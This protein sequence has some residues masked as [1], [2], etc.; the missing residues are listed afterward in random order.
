MA[1]GVA[2]GRIC[3]TTFNSPTPKTFYWAQTSQ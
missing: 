3:L 1:A 2:R